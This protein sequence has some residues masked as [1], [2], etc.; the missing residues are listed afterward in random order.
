MVARL[1]LLLLAVGLFVAIWS[2]DRPAGSTARDAAGNQTAD[3]KM[4]KKPRWG[5]AVR[6]P[7]RTDVSSQSPLPPVEASRPRHET[8]QSTEVSIQRNAD[9]SLTSITAAGSDATTTSNTVE[10]TDR[11]PL[12]GGI[13][14]GEYRVVRSDG[15]VL[16]LRLSS[17]EL[18]RRRMS[19]AE[20][21]KDVYLLHDG[22]VR[23]YFIRVQPPSETVIARKPDGGDDAHSP[24]VAR[25]PKPEDRA[26]RSRF[27]RLL[28]PPRTGVWW[29]R[30]T[31]DR[32]QT[33]VFDGAKRSARLGADLV[34]ESLRRMQNG[35]SRKP[36]IAAERSPAQR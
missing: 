22:R 35:F 33:T 23:W 32:L 16:R 14:P 5:D 27:A 18:C 20:S 30:T 25:K 13:I 6:N 12:P 34:V 24:A 28:Q 8:A 4:S 19:K 1:T 26:R 17:S 36:R 15:R 31:W 29:I 21:P 7:V 2:A 9:R 3:S 10:S 11:I